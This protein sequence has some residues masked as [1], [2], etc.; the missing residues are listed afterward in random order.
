[1]SKMI[2]R[3]TDI[4]LK[5]GSNNF[6]FLF[7][8]KELFS[9]V[10]CWRDSV[11]FSSENKQVSYLG[12]HA[13][14]CDAPQNMYTRVQMDTVPGKKRRSYTK[15]FT[16]R[17]KPSEWSSRPFTTAAI[18]WTCFYVLNKSWKSQWLKIFCI[19]YSD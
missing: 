19:E 7:K 2:L 3:D 14:A 4:F 8:I 17:H 15:V 13:S 16:S 10:K 5:N 12:L 9:V 6:F 11:A 18:Y 1:M